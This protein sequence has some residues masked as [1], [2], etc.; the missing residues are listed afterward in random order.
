MQVFILY[1]A[2]VLIWGSTWSIIRFQLGP[3]ATE[4]SIVYRFVLASAVL[5][6]YALL[7]RRRIGIPSE[8]YFMVIIQ[9]A[10]LF[11]ANYMFV[12]L[13]TSYIT[14]GL[15]AVIFSSLVALNIINERIFFGTPM[16]GK[17]IL[18]LLLGLLGIVLIFWPEVRTL[19]LHSETLLGILY[20]LVAALMASLGNM[21]AIVNTRRGLPVVALNA[22]GMAWGALIAALIALLLGRPFNFSWTPEYVW[23]L[24]YL[25]IP[26]S[27]MAFG[28]YLALMGRIGS[29]KAAYTTILFPVVAL[30]ISTLVEDYRWSTIAMLGVAVSLAGN[31]LA[32]TAARPLP[33]SAAAQ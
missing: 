11:C 9:G 7:A 10:L 33:R 4:V 26:A 15:V 32:L 23:S 12:Y 13:G 28:F 16:S 21:A 31:W 8:H 14:S 30:L 27:A 18:A 24:M 22:H 19:D 6:V 5:F 29:V 1:A 17:V 2:V 25:A 20:V 3:V